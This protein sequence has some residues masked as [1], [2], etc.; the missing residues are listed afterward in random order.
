LFYLKISSLWFCFILLFSAC[1]ETIE[2]KKKK[3][4]INKI[5]KVEKLLTLGKYQDAMDILMKIRKKHKKNPEFWNMFGLA[6]RYNAYF[7]KDNELRDEEI[8]A[9]KKAVKLDSKNPIYIMNLANSYWETGKK[10]EARIL[11]EKVLVLEPKHKNKTGIIERIKIPEKTKISKPIIKK[12]PEVENVKPPENP[13]SNMASEKKLEKSP[14][15]K[16]VKTLEKIDNKKPVVS[17]PENP[18][19]KKNL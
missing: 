8:K 10:K 2:F 18:K 12:K 3:S 17:P 7:E 9:F 19:L 4:N 15:K 13:V 1:S 14:E 6:L 5:S 16:P 11:Y